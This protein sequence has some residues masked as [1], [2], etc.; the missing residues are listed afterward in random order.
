MSADEALF[1]EIRPDGQVGEYEAMYREIFKPKVLNK[2]EL[3]NLNNKYYL[4]ETLNIDKITR[5]LKDKKIKKAIVAQLKTKY[6]IESNTKI[7]K[8]MSEGKFNEKQFQKFS[9]DNNLEIKKIIIK[10]IKNETVFDSDIS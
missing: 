3:I 4:S 10:D 2:P 8:E 6:I 5:S 1:H 7:I 9:K